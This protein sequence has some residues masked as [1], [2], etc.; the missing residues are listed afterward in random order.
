MCRRGISQMLE[1]AEVVVSREPKESAWR[2]GAILSLGVSTLLSGDQEAADLIL[3]EAAE[4]GGAS[5]ASVGL[6]ERSLIAMSRG[7]WSEAGG[8]VQRALGV[9]EAAGLHEFSQSAI[10]FAAS[11]HCAFHAGNLDLARRELNRAQRL[12]PLLTRAIPWFSVQTRLELARVC[13]GLSDPAGARVLLS[14]IADILGKRPDLGILN[15]EVADLRR[16]LDSWHRAGLPG[17]SALS[18]AELRLLPL[19]TTHLSFAEIG[20]QLHV[21]KTTVKSEAISIYRK[22]GAS[23][24][25]EAVQQAR[26]IG[27]LDA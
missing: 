1:D 15:E 13:L 16:T 25:S 4:S 20:Q 21:S 9:V 22:L 6:S 8:Y 23:S 17:P 14:E 12:R 11:A 27:L 18:T 3:A 26:Q 7:K 24:R 10:T 5:A 19:L 2:G